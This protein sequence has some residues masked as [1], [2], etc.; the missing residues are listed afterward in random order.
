MAG[1]TPSGG[2]RLLV[3]GLGGIVTEAARWGAALGMRVSGTR[4]SSR[5]GPEFV[6][7]VGLSP[8]LH[9][10]AAQADVIVNALP[11]TPDTTD[12]LDGEFFATVKPGAL[13]IHVGRG[14][15]VVT[16]ERIAALE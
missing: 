9:D 10:L 15:T 7:Y 3:V 6:E 5:D 16:A 8:E 4:N 14:Q 13:F 2:K 12:L 11:L 1:M